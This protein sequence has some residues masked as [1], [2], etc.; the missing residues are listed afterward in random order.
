MR[1]AL[2][3]SPVQLAYDLVDFPS[4]SR[5]EAEIVTALAESLSSYRHLQV[6]RD[7]N[8]LI[9]TVCQDINRQNVASQGPKE[10]VIV[11]GHVDTVPIK[12][13]GYAQ[14]VEREGEKYLWGRGSVDM[15]SGLACLLNVAAILENPRVDVTYV[16]YDCEE[17]EESANG[18]KRLLAKYPEEFS[19]AKLAIIAEPTGGKIEAGCN[20]TLRVLLKTRGITAHSARAWKG[21]NAIHLAAPLLDRLAKYQPKNVEIDGLVYREGLNCT[22]ISGGVA[23]NSIPDECTLTVNYRFAPNKTG[24][25]AIAHVE[26]VFAGLDYELIVDDLS[27]GAMPGL[28]TQLGSELLE[29]CQGQVGPKYG[30]TDVA[31]FAALGI[32]ALNFGPGDPMD[33]HT[34]QEACRVSEIELVRERLLNFLK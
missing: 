26:E 10:R 6:K 22:W 16:V 27:L 30:W 28:G 9:A 23:K 15:K 13:N 1:F 19:G 29:L 20:G 4:V 31:R 34:D 7:G 17:I 33:C 25:E 18:L 14:W 32:P 12:N 21:K 2:S 8:A 11:A 24:A 5:E 3:D